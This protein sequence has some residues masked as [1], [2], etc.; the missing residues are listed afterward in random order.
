MITSGIELLTALTDALIFVVCLYCYL[1]ITENKLWKFFFLLM[2]ICS[3][4]GTVAHGIVLSSKMMDLIWVVLVLFF[5]VTANTLL[6]IFMKSKAV[7]VTVLSL[8]V[9]VLL[10]IQMILEMDYLF[11]FTIYALIIVLVSFYYIIKGLYKSDKWLI[12]GF[13]IQFI[14]GVVVFSKASI[15]TF[16]HNCIYHTLL[17]ITLLCFYKSIKVC[18]NNN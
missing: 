16:N 8:L 3:F 7:T 17:A 2:G 4:L 1:R 13:V 18:Y 6:G 11:T 14:G 12:I 9:S 5:S 15:Y 10:L